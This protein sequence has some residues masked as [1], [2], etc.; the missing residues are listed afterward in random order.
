MRA[1]VVGVHKL[2]RHD[3]ELKRL[4]STRCLGNRSLEDLSLLTLL[5]EGARGLF[6][7]SLVK[8]YSSLQAKRKRQLF[9]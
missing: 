1:A 6:T 7:L 8:K 9:G 3:L 5:S 4:L 2:R